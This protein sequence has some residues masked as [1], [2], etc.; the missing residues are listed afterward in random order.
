VYCDRQHDLCRR[1]QTRRESVTPRPAAGG[2]VLV[3][4]SSPQIDQKKA[5]YGRGSASGNF[6]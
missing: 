3:V 6:R 4:E 1:Q 2:E 5:I